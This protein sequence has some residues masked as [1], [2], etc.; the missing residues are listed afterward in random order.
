MGAAAST[1]KDQADFQ[2]VL[3]SPSNNVKPAVQGSTAASTPIMTAEKKLKVAELNLNSFTISDLKKHNNE[4]TLIAENKLRRDDS[5]A[6]LVFSILDGSVSTVDTRNEFEQTE[7][8]QRLNMFSEC[9][10]ECSQ[11]TKFVF[12]GGFKVAENMQLMNSKGIKRIVN[13][14]NAIVPCHYLE[15]FQYLSLNLMDGRMEDISWYICQVVQFIVEGT[16]KGE[17]TLIHCEKG[18]SRSCALAIG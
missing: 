6:S 5:D 2:G 13:C 3:P 14:A 4:T 16:N 1:R 12:V 7:S 15:D 10:N 11:I 18:I 17:R 8:Q 9:E